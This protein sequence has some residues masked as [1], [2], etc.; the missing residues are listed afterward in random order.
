MMC[1]QKAGMAGVAGPSAVTS[2]AAE[3]RC[4]AVFASLRMVSVKA[5][6]R[7]DGPAT[8][9]PASV[10]STSINVTLEHKTSHKGHFLKLRFIHHLKAE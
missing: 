1:L 5:S 7:R 4:A 6:W 9:S 10:S 8:L 2:A 3:S